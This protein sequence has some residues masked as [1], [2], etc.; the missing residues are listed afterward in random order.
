MVNHQIGKQIIGY[1]LRVVGGEV[2]RR[3]D[4]WVMGIKEG[5]WCGEHWVLHETDELLNSKAV[6]NDVGQQLYVG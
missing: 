6:T 4:N 5:M 3:K 1:K 2:S